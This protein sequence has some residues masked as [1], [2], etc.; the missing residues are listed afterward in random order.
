MTIV[1]VRDER[2]NY[3]L[4]AQLRDGE[5]VLAASDMSAWIEAAMGTEEYEY[6]YVIKAADMGRVRALLG[7]TDEEVL[8][9]IRELLAPH[10]ISAS[11]AW[12]SWLEANRIPYDFSVWR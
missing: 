10:G 1:E 4:T 5:L 3:Q 9:R 11:T 6:F 2:T 7:T 12:K 8:A